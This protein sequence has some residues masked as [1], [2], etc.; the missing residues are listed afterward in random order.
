MAKV[1]EETAAWSSPEHV[2]EFEG[3][4]IDG[5]ADTGAAESGPRAVIPSVSMQRKIIPPTAVP[6]RL[7]IRLDAES[8]TR[9]ARTLDEELPIIAAMNRTYAI[10]LLG[11]TDRRCAC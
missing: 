2:R 3:V 6:T 9:H 10:V 11:A 4:T 7:R 8:F 5:A 1:V